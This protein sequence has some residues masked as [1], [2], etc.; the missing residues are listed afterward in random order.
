LETVGRLF[1][2]LVVAQILLSGC[3]ESDT[4]TSPTNSCRLVEVTEL[5]VQPATS[6]RASPYYPLQAMRDT[7]SGSA[8]IAIWVGPDSLVCETEVVEW[9]GC[10][11]FGS[12]SEL[13]ARQSRYTAG[14][15]DG[16]PVVSRID[17]EFVFEIV[18]GAN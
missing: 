6:F 15:K 13:A 14:Q 11:C 5:D 18:E 12:A 7:I 3:S 16:V 2:L 4:G 9:V 1:V 8:T 10:E 17:L